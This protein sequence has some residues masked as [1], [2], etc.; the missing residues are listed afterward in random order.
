MNYEEEEKLFK[1]R[2]TVFENRCK[3]LTSAC[4]GFIDGTTPI[5]DV[6]ILLVQ[7]YSAADEFEDG[8]DIFWD[9]VCKAYIY[10]NDKLD[11][12]VKAALTSTRLGYTVYISLRDRSYYL[13]CTSEKFGSY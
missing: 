8:V 4:Q 12:A 3:D 5:N 2:L 9:D 1:N 11:S 6:L 7:C 13:D 10:G